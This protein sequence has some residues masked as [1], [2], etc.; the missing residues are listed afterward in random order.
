M[1]LRLLVSGDGDGE[2]DRDARRRLRLLRAAGDGIGASSP[3]GTTLGSFRKL[4]LPLP[5]SI[6][7]SRSLL[8]DLALLIL[9]RFSDSNTSPRRFLGDVSLSLL[10]LT[11]DVLRLSRVTSLGG[12]SSLGLRLPLAT[13]TRILFSLVVL[14]LA[15]LD[16]RRLLLSASDPDD[17]GDAETDPDR[18]PSES[19]SDSE[20]DS[21]DDED[22]E[23]PEVDS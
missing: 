2:R 20:E 8:P 18:D 12:L 9:T 7:S 5:V 14:F 22:D 6:P 23:E 21:D 3:V 13:S 4:G 19:D 15:L 1:L 11:R 16:L 17:E 10:A